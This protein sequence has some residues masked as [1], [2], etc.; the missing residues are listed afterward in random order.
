ML[1]AGMDTTANTLA[2]ILDLLS[3]HQDVQ[4]KLRTEVLQA[5]Q[6]HGDGETLDFDSL[7]DL[8]YLEAVCRESF[9]VCAHERF[10]RFFSSCR[11]SLDIL[12][13][14]VCSGSKYSL[15]RISVFSSTRCLCVRL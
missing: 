11:R 14:H 1:I 7:M 6:T 9:R 10:Y 4:D 5:V 8:P 13:L 3:Q 12:A 15:K 2:H